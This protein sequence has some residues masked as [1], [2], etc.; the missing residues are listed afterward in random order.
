MW[1]EETREGLIGTYTFYGTQLV[2]ATWKPYRIYDYGQPVFMNPKDSA[3]ALQTMEAASDQLAARL[4]EPKTSP[5][6]AMP[7]PPPYAP[8]S[9]P[10]S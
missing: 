8:E 9:A 5:I 10:K 7:G 2:S 4:G 6:P 1:S 3:T